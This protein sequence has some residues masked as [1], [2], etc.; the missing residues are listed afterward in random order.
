[1]ASSKKVPAVEKAVQI[2]QLYS[3]SS[4]IYMGVTE[5]A[6]ALNLNKGTVHSI[7][8]TL[9]DYDF[10]VKSQIS[11]E[12][13]LGP[14]ITTVA[15]AYARH[16]EIIRCF[17]EIIFKHRPS[18]PEAFGCIILKR[19][20]LNVLAFNPAVNT[21]LGVNIP[22]GSIFPPAFS[23]AGKVLLARFDDTSIEKLYDLQYQEVYKDKI[24]SREDFIKGIQLVR[25]E[26]YCLYDH[27]LGEDICGISAPLK[28]EGGKT[29]AAI[30]MFIPKM[31]LS[32]ALKEEYINTVLDISKD[33]ATE[34]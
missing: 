16:E 13:A 24:E 5:I 3:S 29:V 8:N 15:N 6:N 19:E 10:I 33:I 34:F 4:A 18:C 31:R 30:S 23:S 1:M 20:K 14:A 21:C 17:D 26:G 27:E 32:S 22:T 7:L 2:L 9:M 25:E 12:Y 28:N 11:G